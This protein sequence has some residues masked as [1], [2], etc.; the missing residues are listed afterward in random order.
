MYRKGV[1][2]VVAALFLTLT[3]ITIAGS[4]Y[5][6]FN[7]IISSKSSN[8]LNIVDATYGKITVK[9]IGTSDISSVTATVDG[10]PVKVS[11]VNS[12]I[13]AGTTG[14]IILQ[15]LPPVRKLHT[16]KLIAG[17]VA[18]VFTWDYP[19]IGLYD[20]DADGIAK[21]T[22]NH[23][24][25][26]F[27][28][29]QLYNWL[30][31]SG[32]AVKKLSSDEWSGDSLSLNP[33]LENPWT[34]I[35]N[36]DIYHRI[37][38][39]NNWT[40]EYNFGTSDIMYAIN[41]TLIVYDGGTA[42]RMKFKRVAI[43]P[44]SNWLAIQNCYQGISRFKVDRTLYLEGG[45]FQN[46]ISQSTGRFTD[47]SFWFYDS[48]GA[49]ISRVYGSN[50]I[51]YDLGNGWYYVSTLLPP[52]S[53]PVNAVYAC[54]MQY[55]VWLGGGL[56]REAVFDKI[57]TVPWTSMPTTQDRIDRATKQIPKMTDFD[58]FIIPTGEVYPAR[59]KS[60]NYTG[61]NIWNITRE[62]LTKG[63][64]LLVIGAW[65]FYYPIRWNTTW[66]TDCR[67]DSSGGW[68][69]DADLAPCGSA[70]SNQIRLDFSVVAGL[71]LIRTAD[72]AAYF[73]NSPGYSISPIDLRPLQKF[74]CSSNDYKQFWVT[75]IGPAPGISMISYYNCPPYTGKILKVMGNGTG[76]T[77]LDNI[78]VDHVT[79]LGGQSFI[80]SAVLTLLQY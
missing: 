78:V 1:S 68:I 4:A 74:T 23:G 64:K 65:P 24:W 71:S 41:E 15:G 45:D 38:A 50:N 72:G 58:A 77:I 8:I 35:S 54:F 69:S 57:K 32:F 73:P 63:G 70:A 10:Q 27:S 51:N 40:I 46:I 5:L 30:T 33:S 21:E 61:G 28:S 42:I 16:L 44:D 12:P 59:G 29:T 53:I 56:D 67:P 9:N 19:I 49:V 80:E 31:G 48:N 18:K 66:T 60:Y 36:P 7:A 11:I 26:N 2:P 13:K 62:Y 55:F 47:Q 22:L 17:G 37:E 52:A 39:P 3:L 6:M 75:D 76:A 43:T 79:K 20:N 14:T 34:L 25:G